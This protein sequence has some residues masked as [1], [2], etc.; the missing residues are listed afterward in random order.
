MHLAEADRACESRQD[1][2][3]PVA[4]TK[5]RIPATASTVL[6]RERLHLLLEAAVARTDVGPPVTVVCAPAGSGKTTA[7]ATWARQRLERHG[8]WIAWVSLE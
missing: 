2:E 4:T 3:P 7:L 8:A 6:I 5:V 1:G